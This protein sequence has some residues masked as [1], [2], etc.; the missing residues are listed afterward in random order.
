MVNQK[1]ITARSLGLLP[2]TVLKI[3]VGERWNA[4]AEYLGVMSYGK[5]FPLNNQYMSLGGHVLLP[6]N[7]ELGL[8]FGFGLN[9]TTTHFFN[10]VGIGWRF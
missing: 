7:V 6:P 2:S 8:R 4:H 1:A 3:P 9:E 10:N 5:E